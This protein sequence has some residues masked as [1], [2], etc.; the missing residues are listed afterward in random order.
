MYAYLFFGLAILGIFSIFENLKGQQK[1]TFFKLNIL[2]LLFI[3]T[4]NSILDFNGGSGFI[5][6]FTCQLF[7]MLGT[8]LTIN[9]F[10]LI[11]SKKIPKIVIWI[12]CFVIIIYIVQ[13][14]Y[15]FRFPIF[16]EGRIITGITLF[17]VIN[18]FFSIFLILG[19]M[20]YNLYLINKIK[21]PLNLYQQKIKSWSYLLFFSIFIILFLFGF[22]IFAYLKPSNSVYID[23]RIGYIAIR[24][25]MIV[26]ILFR[27][28][29]IDEAGLSPI[30]FNY[31]S[32]NQVISLQKFD[33]L[34]Y[35]SHYFLHQEASIEDFALKLNHPKS[36]I[37]GFLKS[38]NLDSFNE[39]LNKSR[40]NY[41]K[42]LLKSGKHK[43]F[44]I[45]A[46]SEMSGFNNRQ[47]MYNSF[48][49]YEGCS[50]TEFINNL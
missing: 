6:V 8:I 1:L 20:G 7:R 38:Q 2:G 39:L 12:E 50:P 17:N 29:F 13:I 15:G 16:K 46:L 5:Y 49:K 28:K 36:E 44:T 31:V 25:L 47:T 22:G 34:F 45:E 14:I 33:F 3:I 4:L 41:F 48:K 11:A 30:N 23:S 24:Y 18:T 40:T 26:F 43:S 10:Y 35:T 9:L 19:S 27:P 32:A 21:Q 37:F 42:E